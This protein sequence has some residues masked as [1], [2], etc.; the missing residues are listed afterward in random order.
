VIQNSIKLIKS[1][2]KNYIEKMLKI[3]TWNMCYWQHRNLFSD[4]WEYL[5][6]KIN[7]DI[8]LLQ[9]TVPPQEENSLKHFVWQTIGEKRNWGS[10]I[11]SK[12]P[13]VEVIFGNS[14]SGYVTVGEVSI[15]NNAKLTVVSIHAPLE[16]T[17]SIIPLHRIFSDL[18]LLLEGRMGNRTI[19]LGGDFNASI[20]WDRRQKNESHRIFF[21][22]VKNFGLC[23]CL[24]KFYTKPIQT[25]RHPQGNTPW[26]LDHLFIS[27]EVEN[28]LQKCY[29][30]ENENIVKFSD[31]NPIVAELNI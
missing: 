11:F 7:P 21:E 17:Y 16:D 26:Q 23:D 12:Y 13:V 6:Q 20:Q 9:E 1:K 8:A 4:S 29:V 25:Y 30:I 28:T 22:R 18:T 2:L 27:N 15:L 3:V 10:G 14:Y 24:G 31:H 5:S 19:V